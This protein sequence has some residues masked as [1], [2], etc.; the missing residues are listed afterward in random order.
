MTTTSVTAS[1]SASATSQQQSAAG[2]GYGD[3]GQSDFFRLLTTQLMQQDPTNPVDNT[4]ML[5]QMAQFTSL[6][7]STEMND[8]LKQISSKLDMLNATQSAAAAAGAARDAA[9]AAASDA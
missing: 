5:A 8:T 1:S 6:S 9:V 2:R 7:N 4:D 3:L